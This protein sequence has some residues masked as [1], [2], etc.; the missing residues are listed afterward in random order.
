MA[1]GLTVLFAVMAFVNLGSM[2]AP[3]TAYEFE[4]NDS[5]GNEMVLR[6]DGSVTISEAQVYLGGKE[7]RHFVCV[8]SEC[9]GDG[10][11]ASGKR[12][13]CYLYTAGIQWKFIT[14]LTN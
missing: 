1:A 2:K 3:Q 9:E 6:F 8:G 5:H 11:D 13:N 7:K 10:W 12:Q 4:K 14:A